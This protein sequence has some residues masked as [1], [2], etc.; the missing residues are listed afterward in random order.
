MATC[1]AAEASRPG[2]MKSR[3]GTPS[4]PPRLTN[5]PTEMPMP[6]RNSTDSTN[7]EKTEPRQTR[8]YAAS[9]C[10]RTASAPLKGAT[11]GDA[12]LRTVTSVLH[13]GAPGQPE[14]HVLQRAAPDQHAGRGE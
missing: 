4:M 5:V 10:S 3:Y 1:R 8:R 12:P 6:S 7:V 13:Q 9:R 11:R 14:E 2:A